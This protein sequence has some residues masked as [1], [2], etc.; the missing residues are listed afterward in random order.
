MSEDR[1][2]GQAPYR[3]IA[4]HGGPGACGE[5]APVASELSQNL[6]V[7]ETL[8]TKPTIRGQINELKRAVE[9]EATIPV[10][11]VG[12]SWGAW[13]SL[14]FAAEYTD[15][16]S[17]LILIGSAPFAPE[18]AEQIGATRLS[19]MSEDERDEFFR[20][21]RAMEDHEA[22]GKTEEFQ[23]LARLVTR[24]DAYEPV[25]EAVDSRDV[26][27]RVDVFQSVWPAAR[28]MRQN[29]EILEYL[30]RVECPIRAIHGDHDPHPAEGVQKTLEAL[31]VDSRFILLDRCGHAP[32]LERHARDE[33][34]RVLREELS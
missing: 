24:S 1:F 28:R 12:H 9:A 31:P 30:Q 4:V 34:F 32:W 22:V 15:R 7:I 23:R 8:H 10:I 20:L 26:D 13:L 17:K 3:I 16:V 27:Y 29:G 5:L 14:M 33:F 6:S 18:Y 25:D 2:H 21:E 19:R 11:L